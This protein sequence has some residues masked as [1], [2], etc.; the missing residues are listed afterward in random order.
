MENSWANQ[1]INDRWENARNQRKKVVLNFE[2]LVHF[3]ISGKRVNKTHW[4]IKHGDSLPT[5]IRV[6]QKSA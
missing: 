1:K 2:K 6:Y 5:L 3:S 4:K